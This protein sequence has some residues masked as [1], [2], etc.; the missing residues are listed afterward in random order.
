MGEKRKRV[1]KKQYAV[2]EALLKRTQDERDEAEKALK[3][4]RKTSQYLGKRRA[5]LIEDRNYWSALA[6]AHQQALDIIQNLTTPKEK[7]KERNFPQGEG[8]T[9]AVAVAPDEPQLSKPGWVK[10]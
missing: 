1:T 10:R 5:E 8:A 6:A 7:P 2:L 9:M 4:E 3:Q